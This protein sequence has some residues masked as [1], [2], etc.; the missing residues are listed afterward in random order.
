MQKILLI[1]TLLVLT[2][3]IVLNGQTFEINNESITTCTGS[4]QD[5]NGGIGDAPGTEGGPYSNTSYT[6]T[7]CPDVPG[8]VI[9]INF[10]A[11]NLYTN[12]N[13]NNSDY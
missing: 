8:D 4:F 13:P 3:S 11:F 2:S 7:I 9:Q 1:T 10:S 6:Y 5:D 12:L